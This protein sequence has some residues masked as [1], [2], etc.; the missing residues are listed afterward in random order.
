MTTLNCVQ[1]VVCMADTF[2]KVNII[3]THMLTD[4]SLFKN[5]KPCRTTTK[6]ILNQQ[7]AWLCSS[8]Y[9][10]RLVVSIVDKVESYLR[11]NNNQPLLLMLPN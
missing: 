6:L 2:T 7:E 4:D 9:L 11:S 1:S 5:G 3:E 8:L 10:N